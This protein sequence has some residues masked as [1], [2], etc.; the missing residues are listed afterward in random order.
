MQKEG[1]DALKR[2]AQM[3]K[4]RLRN[5]VMEKE[6][7]A[8][9]NRSNFKIICGCGVDIKCKIITKD[10]VKLYAKVKALL[11]ENIDI[12]NPISRLIDYKMFNKMD[13]LAQERYL[14]DLVEKFKRYKEKYI[15]EKQAQIG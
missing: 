3:A 5:K 15:I 8:V 12:T 7:K 4:N 9:K 11:E 6:N 1:M 10:D 14:F 13:E 2:M